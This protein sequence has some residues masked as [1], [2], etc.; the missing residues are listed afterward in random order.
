MIQAFR[1]PVKKQTIT[2]CLM[3]KYV[4]KEKQTQ[5]SKIEAKGKSSL[6]CRVRFGTGNN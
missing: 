2:P 3:K 1:K 5:S 4:A 6:I